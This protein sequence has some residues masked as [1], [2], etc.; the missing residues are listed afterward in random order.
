MRTEIYSDIKTFLD[1]V[2][3]VEGVQAVLQQL[4]NFLT[5]EKRE[6]DIELMQVLIYL[7]MF[8][9]ILIV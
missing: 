5:T 2:G 4:Y 7:I 3:K 1:G 8:L 9:K 6:E